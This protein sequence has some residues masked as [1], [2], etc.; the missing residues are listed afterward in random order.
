MRQHRILSAILCCAFPC[1]AEWTQAQ[2]GWG[3]RTGA[4]LSQMSGD[5]YDLLGGAERTEGVAQ[6]DRNI[7]AD[8]WGIRSRADLLRTIP[9][10]LQAASDRRK[11]GWNYPRA[12]HL[13]RWGYAAGYLQEQEAWNLIM[14]AAGSLQQTFSSWQEF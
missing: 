2:K 6:K 12:V 5:R 10:L 9:E 4:M 11:I 14:P 13:A 7:L 3:L 1:A 8:S